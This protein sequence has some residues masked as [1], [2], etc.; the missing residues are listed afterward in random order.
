MGIK[1]LAKV[2]GDHAPNSIKENEMKN[3]F[4]KFKLNNYWLK[5]LNFVSACVLKF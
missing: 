4:G 5:K 2:I 3:Y 1:D